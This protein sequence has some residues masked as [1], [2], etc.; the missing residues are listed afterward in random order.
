M[1]WRNE[2]RHSGRAFATATQGQQMRQTIQV[3]INLKQRMRGGEHAHTQN[4]VFH[5]RASKEQNCKPHGIIPPL[6][7]GEGK[8]L[9]IETPLTLMKMGG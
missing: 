4:S 6:I 3:L 2:V 9:Y 7:L 8:S 5:L 1:A